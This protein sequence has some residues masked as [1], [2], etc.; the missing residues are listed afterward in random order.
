VLVP[1]FGV[2]LTSPTYDRQDVLWVGG[3]STGV[4]HLWAINTSVDFADATKSRPQVIEAGWLSKRLVTSVRLSPDGQRIAVISTD[5]KGGDPQLDVAGVVRQPNG[6][7][8]SVGEPLTLAPALT[9]MR[10]LVWTDDT[11]LA[12]LGRKASSQV[13]RPWFVPLGGPLSAGPEIAGAQAITTVNGE[14]G[15][16]VV[17]DKDEVLIRAGNRW[18]S[19]GTGSAFLVAGR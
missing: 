5:R 9:L 11:T 2:G 13:V 18:Q 16:V 19:V 8:T 12:V 17:T 7:P 3:L 6:L 14:R 1:A 4:A 10:D 15:L